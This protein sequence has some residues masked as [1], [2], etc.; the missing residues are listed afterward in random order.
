MDLPSKGEKVAD[1]LQEVTQQEKRLLDFIDDKPPNWEHTLRHTMKKYV[2]IDTDIPLRNEEQHL[3]LYN[4]I[5]LPYWESFTNAGRATYLFDNFITPWQVAAR[6]LIHEM[7]EFQGLWQLRSEIDFDYEDALLGGLTKGMRDTKKRGDSPNRPEIDVL[8]HQLLDIRE[9]IDEGDKDLKALQDWAI[10]HGDSVTL[11]GKIENIDMRYALFELSRNG[12]LEEASDARQ[13]DIDFYNNY[14]V[15]ARNAI[16]L[17]ADPEHWTKRLFRAGKEYAPKLLDVPG[18]I[19]EYVTKRQQLVDVLNLEGNVVL[20]SEASDEMKNS[21]RI[22]RQSL[23][24]KGFFESPWALEA[25]RWFERGFFN[26]AWDFGKRY[27]GRAVVAGIGAYAGSAV[28][29]IGTVG[30]GLGGWAAAEEMGIDP[31][32]Q[33]IRKFRLGRQYRNGL[34]ELYH[35]VTRML[36]PEGGMRSI[37]VTDEFVNNLSNNYV[38]LAGDDLYTYVTAIE[39]IAKDKIIGD[40]AVTFDWYEDLVSHA[41]GEHPERIFMDA[42]NE[43]IDRPKVWE[44]LRWRF[45]GYGDAKAM[46][47]GDYRALEQFVLHEQFLNCGKISPVLMRSSLIEASGE[48]S[49]LGYGEIPIDP[50]ELAKEWVTPDGALKPGG[51][52]EEALQLRRVDAIIGNRGFTMEAMST[53]MENYKKALDGLSNIGAEVTIKKFDPLFLL[54]PGDEPIP[55]GDFVRA[56]LKQYFN[57]NDIEERKFIKEALIDGRGE[58]FDVSGLPRGE[59]LDSLL[60]PVMDTLTKYEESNKFIAE[61]IETT[62][63]HELVRADAASIQEFFGDASTKMVQDIEKLAPELTGP[64]ERNVLLEAM[65]ERLETFEQFGLVELN[66]YKPLP[67]LRTMAKAATKYVIAALKF[68]LRFL[69]ENFLWGLVLY[70]VIQIGFSSYTLIHWNTSLAPIPTSIVFMTPWQIH[71][72]KAEGGTVQTIGNTAVR[73]LIGDFDY[74][75]LASWPYLINTAT[76]EW[77]WLRDQEGTKKFGYLFGLLDPLQWKSIPFQ[78]NYM[79]IEEFNANV[80]YIN[81]QDVDHFKNVFMNHTLE[82][83]KS[84][85]GLHQEH[86]YPPHFHAGSDFEHYVYTGKEIRSELRAKISNWSN[87]DPDID[88][89]NSL[90]WVT[91]VGKEGLLWPGEHKQ[92]G[93][94]V[95]GIDNPR[96]VDLVTYFSGYC[97]SSAA[98]YRGTFGR[99]FANILKPNDVGTVITA[100]TPEQLQHDIAFLASLGMLNDSWV[101]I[102][103]IGVGRGTNSKKLCFSPFSDYYFEVW[104]E[105]NR[106]DE[107]G[108]S[109]HR[110]VSFTDPARIK[111]GLASEAYEKDPYLKSYVDMEVAQ[112]I[113]PMMVAQ[114]KAKEHAQEK[115]EEEKETTEEEEEETTTEEEEEEDPE[116]DIPGTE[117]TEGERMTKLRRLDRKRYSGDNKEASKMYATIKINPTWHSWLEMMPH[118]QLKDMLA[119]DYGITHIREF[120][121]MYEMGFTEYS[122]YQLYIDLMDMQNTDPDSQE[123]YASKPHEVKKRRWLP[124]WNSWVIAVVRGLNSKWATT[125]GE[126]KADY[127]AARNLA[128]TEE[129]AQMLVDKYGW[130]TKRKFVD[131]YRW[132]GFAY[133]SEYWDFILALRKINGN[134]YLHTKSPSDIRRHQPDDWLPQ[135]SKDVN[136]T[137][138]YNTYIEKRTQPEEEEEE[139]IPLS[140]VVS[141][142]PSP[143]PE[144]EEPPP[145]PEPEEEEEDIITEDEEVTT[146]EEPTPPPSPEPVEEESPPPTPEPEEESPR[147]TPPPTPEPEEEEEEDD[148]PP[149]P[150]QNPPDDEEA[151]GTD[152]TPPSEPTPIFSFPYFVKLLHRVH[153]TGQVARKTGGYLPTE[154]GHLRDFLV[155][156]PEISYGTFC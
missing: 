32:I 52:D 47:G 67:A 56:V 90:F 16:L 8:I 44:G 11:F 65:K 119:A 71:K 9:G 102:D 116:E 109:W 38:S 64:I 68:G 118:S 123:S 114:L 82:Y 42:E 127:Y 78:S 98:G 124:Q 49:K 41:E 92:S 111:R 148:D 153:S 6:K 105:Y 85:N 35:S 97:T 84:G 103:G 17:I 57:T 142:T 99:L 126:I 39:A 15:L 59:S 93:L 63:E 13:E 69:A 135:S 95:E 30:L 51:V 3:Q 113:I 74:T 77:T 37:E 83:R 138:Y 22:L 120:V 18:M 94:E 5:M 23:A 147:P 24:S 100:D 139:D 129:E 107:E 133:Y 132:K 66:A 14:R 7:I 75:G 46:T 45:G 36:H 62:I 55:A 81:S 72:A 141:P 136:Q 101:V 150:V 96:G 117:V 155:M 48:R 50:M 29:P 130:K 28:G 152:E 145:S 76:L 128:L 21:A 88:Y 137:Y 134:T 143:P 131:G 60:R 12:F 80:T 2:L 154:G 61:G 58:F 20:L 40:P 122:D 26:T 86:Y 115:E 140:P 125:N 43:K 34:Q 149:G 87:T 79:P 4:D 156:E 106:D 146:E 53:F 10:F 70:P 104:W 91:P 1:A 31:A 108:A 112:T 151:E 73:A 144:E 25:T 19:Y 110:P 27:V 121:N 54:P 89:E 33:G